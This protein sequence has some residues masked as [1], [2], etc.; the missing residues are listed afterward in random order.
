MDQATVL[1][2]DDEEALRGSLSQG[3]ELTGQDV[4]ASGRPESALERINRDFYGVLVTDIRMPGTDGFQVMKNAFEIDPALPVVLITGHGDVPLAV[5]AM[6]AGAYDFLEKPFS[7]AHLASVVE[8]ALDKRRLVLENRKLR[9]ELA[10]RTGLE[11]R[12][13]GRTPAMDLLRKNV[14]ALAATDADI[15]ILGETG[16]GKEVVARAL[17]DEGPRKDKP[18]VALNCGALPAEIIESELFG[19]EKGAFT[20]ASGQRIGKLEHAH[21]GTVFLDEI[22]SMPLELQV[23]LLRVIETRTIERLGSNKAI[24][25][26]VR[27]VAATKEDLEAAGKA[28]RFRLD[29]FYRLNVVN[30]EI[31]PLRD[32]IEDIP[33]LFRHLAVEARARYRREIPDIGELY[34]ADLMARDWPGNV[35]E[36]RNVADRFVLGLEQQSDPQSSNGSSLFEQIATY[37]RALIAAELKRNGGVI[38][39]TYENLGL[40]RK[41]LYEKMRKHGLGK[42]EIDAV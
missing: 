28:G 4:F 10:D 34:L 1:L 41:A 40:S 21:G 22:E 30:V 35:R 38:K 11:S 12:L 25:L 39:P 2:I 20:G 26:D 5:E 18:F 6:R 17:H 29:L 9:E 42:D 13:V 32:R 3:L 14:M 19:H 15:L 8:R 31:P 24:E 7:V 36:L 23:K 33:L 37:E 27:F 16:S